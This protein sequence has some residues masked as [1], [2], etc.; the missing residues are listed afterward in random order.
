MGVKLCVLHL[1]EEHWLRVFENEM[2]RKMFG[3]QKDEVREEWRR[4]H[5][6]AL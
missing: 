3:P 5:K 1:R 6:K 2:L 4:L